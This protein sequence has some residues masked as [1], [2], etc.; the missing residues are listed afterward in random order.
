VDWKAEF[1]FMTGS[2]DFLSLPTCPEQL[3]AFSTPY[4]DS[5]G[6]SPQK[7]VHETYDVKN[8]RMITSIFSNTLMTCLGAKMIWHSR[9]CKS[10]CLR[11]VKVDKHGANLMKI[12]Y[13]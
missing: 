10:P 11:Q 6:C 2:L 4:L 5:R 8:K 1:K 3:Q 7:P 9:I 13:V 12:S